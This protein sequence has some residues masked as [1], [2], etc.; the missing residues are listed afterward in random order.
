MTHV[1]TL[2][3]GRGQSGQVNTRA[4]PIDTK[5]VDPDA[6]PD[7]VADLRL[8]ILADGL[9]LD[10]LRGEQADNFI[11]ILQEAEGLC[12]TILEGALHSTARPFEPVHT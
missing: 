10:P 4:Q 2:K 3:R 9:D 1:I 5:W 12:Y 6:F 7:N 11:D 8:P